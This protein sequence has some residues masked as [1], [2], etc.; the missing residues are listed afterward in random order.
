[1][2]L[3]GRYSYERSAEWYWST[4]LVYLKSR[5]LGSKTALKAVQIAARFN[6][7]V[8]SYLVGDQPMPVAGEPRVP[9]FHETSQ[10]KSVI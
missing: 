1:M 4:A 6:P 2:Q 5:G 10:L 7:H 8:Y 9:K 3:L